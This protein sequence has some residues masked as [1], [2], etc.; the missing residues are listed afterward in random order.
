MLANR[1]GLTR[2]WPI[3]R[4]GTHRRAAIGL[5]VTQHRRQLGLPDAGLQADVE[6]PRPRDFGGLHVRQ[7]RQ[8]PGD[9]G[10]NIARLLPRRLSQHHRGVGREVAMRRIARRLD[11]H[12]ARVEPG[13]QFAAGYKPGNGIGNMRRISMVKRGQSDFR[14]RSVKQTPS[15][16]RSAPDVTGQGEGGDIARGGRPPAPSPRRGEGD[17]RQRAGRGACDARYRTRCPDKHPA[18]PEPVEGSSAH[19]QPFDKLRV[20]G[21]YVEPFTR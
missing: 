19:Q 14:T 6:E 1:K 3:W 2:I 4:A 10:R 20:S 11:R 13:R 21:G 16:A 9:A 15:L 5:A 8:R 17:S 12:A 18:H 7:L